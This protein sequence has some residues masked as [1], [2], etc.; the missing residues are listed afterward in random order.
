MGHFTPKFSEP[1]SSKILI[2]LKNQGV[3]K[4]YGHPPLHAKFGGDPPL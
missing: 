4:W 3:Q 1:L 2:R